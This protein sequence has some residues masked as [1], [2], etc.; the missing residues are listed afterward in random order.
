MPITFGVINAR[1]KQEETRFIYYGQLEL[2]SYVNDKLHD[3][4]ILGRG[5]G[6][7][8]GAAVAVYLGGEWYAPVH[9]H[10][11]N[12]MALVDSE[13]GSLHESYRYGAFGEEFI[14]DGEGY[15]VSESLNPWRFASKRKDPHTHWIAFGQRDYD[16]LLGRWITPDP[17]GFG[18]GPNLYAYVSNRPLNYIDLWGLQAGIYARGEAWEPSR[19][20]V[21]TGIFRRSDGIEAGAHGYRDHDKKIDSSGR[22][23][24]YRGQN[25]SANQNTLRAGIIAEDNS[26][27]EEVLLQ[28][29]IQV[30]YV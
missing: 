16:P 21:S 5:K 7:E 28:M 2:G 14:Q 18:D 11:G 30:A 13:T 20:G 6:S 12:V 17:L 25:N 9:D 3:L 4:R 27:F 15:S 1:V 29:T 10:N 22:D 19:P 8:I 24:S 23:L 26:I